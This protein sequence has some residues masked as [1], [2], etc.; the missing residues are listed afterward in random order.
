VT[1]K[2]LVTNKIYIVTKFIFVTVFLSQKLIFVVV[3]L[4]VLTTVN[5][6]GLFCWDDY[7]GLAF[8]ILIFK[9]ITIKVFSLYVPRFF[10]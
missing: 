10:L 8:A 1:N 2:K 6:G 7:R 5:A 3:T 9:S 4:C